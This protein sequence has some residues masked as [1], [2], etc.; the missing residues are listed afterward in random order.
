MALCVSQSRRDE[1]A[2]G[3]DFY[4]ETDHITSLSVAPGKSGLRPQTVRSYGGK[5]FGVRLGQFVTA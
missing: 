4:L 2:E 3:S 5:K 1:F